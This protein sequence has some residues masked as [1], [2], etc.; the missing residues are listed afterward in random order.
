VCVCVCVCVCVREHEYVYVLRHTFLCVCGVSGCLNPVTVKISASSILNPDP[1]AAV[2]G[3]NVLTSQRVTD[4]ILRA[5]RACAASQVVFLCVS[6]SS[7][8]SS[9]SSRTALSGSSSTHKHMRVAT[10]LLLLLLLLLERV[11]SPHMCDMNR[12]A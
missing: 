11:Y 3:G 4:V 5:F 6:S 12:V 7:S 1:T 9:S 10:V 8:S 2:V